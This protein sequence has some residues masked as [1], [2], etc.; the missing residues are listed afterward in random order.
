M[1]AYDI[2]GNRGTGGVDVSRLKVPV[3][4]AT[5]PQTDTITNRAM[6]P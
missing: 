5:R 3:K 4:I 2:G 6:I 1:H